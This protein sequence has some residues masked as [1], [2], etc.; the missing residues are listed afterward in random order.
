MSRFPDYSRTGY[1]GN[2]GGSYEDTFAYNR[3]DDSGPESR[4]LRS[5]S[6]RGRE[7]RAGG[8]G[9]GLYGEGVQSLRDDNDAN[10]NEPEAPT[11][12]RPTSLERTRA[13]RRSGGQ[14]WQRSPTR[15][16]PGDIGDGSRQIEE[17]LRIIKQDWAFMTEEKCVP[18]QIALQFMDNS[19]LGLES[20]YPRFRELHAQ[21]QSALRQIVNEQHQGFNSSIGRFHNI[22]SALQSSQHRL[23][24]LKESLG[25][26]KSSLST[27]KPELVGLA[28]TTQNYDDMLLTLSDIENLQGIPEQ[29]EA[30][31]SEKRF[32]SAVDLLQSALKTIRKP[33][34]DEIGALSDLKVYLSNQEHSLTDILIEELHS[35]LYLKS[36]YCENRWKE[37][38][39]VHVRG[40]TREQTAVI[41]GRQ[42]YQ[43]L[44]Q[45]DTETILTDDPTKNPEADTFS[46]IHLLVESLNSLGRLDVAVENMAQ[47]LPVELFR[48]VEKCSNEIDQRYPAG[49]RSGR[50]IHDPLNFKD[51]ARTTILNDLFGTLYARFEAIAEGHR[52]VHEVISGITKRD[53]TRGSSALT[54]GFREL[55]KLYQSEIRS[56]LHDYLSSNDDAFRRREIGLRGNN[57]FQKPPRDKTKV[58]NAQTLIYFMC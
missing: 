22:Q 14:G 40:I 35:H 4:S 52:V 1:G 11:L 6:S 55:W 53:G 29:L 56:L 5:G 44:D 24:A 9:M 23:R 48:V 36:P 2:Y 31:I 21:L 37:H 10:N 26:A 57:V 19:S 13:N 28:K 41:G 46:Y 30:R 39:S 33:S 45:L 25:N 27:S 16:P 58:K 51:P 42:L 54:G 15:R 50:G 49:Y 12:P 43:F 47:R 38:A 32:L 7:R 17:V 34:M 3:S 20:R 18:V 8:Y